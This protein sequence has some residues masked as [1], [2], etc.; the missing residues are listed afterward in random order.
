MPP[1]VIYAGGLSIRGSAY[2]SVDLPHP[3][4][5]AMP[6]TSPRRNSIVTSRTA[7]VGRRPAYSTLMC[8]ARR[9]RSGPLPW[10]SGIPLMLCSPLAC[11]GPGGAAFPRR[12]FL[13][14]QSRRHRAPPARSYLTHLRDRLRTGA[15]ALGRAVD[16]QARVEQLVQA[17]VDQREAHAEQC[18]T[19]A[20]RD[21]PPPGP[22]RERLAV[23]REAEHVSPGEQ[24][25]VAQAD[26]R[27]YRLG[28]NREDHAEDEV[29]H[30]DRQ[31]VGQDLDEHDPPGPLPRRPG[32]EHGSS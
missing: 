26:E 7:R 6:S 22:H 3:L 13:A 9:T 4:S 24:R 14:P 30:D 23:I 31:L 17:E 18:D 32:R 5:P 12:S 20:G 1:P 15:P 28:E 19:Q 16:P 8:S 2:A 10:A 27:E 21:E 11:G 29:G 25:R